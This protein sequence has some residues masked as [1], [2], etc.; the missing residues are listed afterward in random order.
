M[1]VFAATALSLFAL[2][3]FRVVEHFA[4]AVE[5]G[6]I[7]AISEALP[8]H[9][10]LARRAKPG[11]LVAQMV[12]PAVVHIVAEAEE[13]DR[14]RPASKGRSLEKLLMD[15]APPSGTLADKPPVAT[16]DG[17]AQSPIPNPQS[18]SSNLQSAIRNPQSM[19]REVGSGFIFNAD[20]GYVLTSAHVTAGGDLIHIFLADDR[21]AL[22]EVVAINQTLDLAVLRIPIRPL[23]KLELADSDLSAIGDDVFAVGSPFGL[24]GTFSKGIVSATDRR[25][26]AISEDEFE[27]L[28]Q[29][30]AVINPGNSGGPL[31]NMRGEVIGVN[32]AIATDGYV[33]D[34]I[35]FAIPANRVTAWLKTLH[36]GFGD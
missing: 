14:E 9:E 20:N 31:V 32:L 4:H 18:P 17:R 7:R 29:T 21:H 8:S 12:A 28:I 1:L 10:E 19:S 3:R 34:G 24:A 5:R 23:H 15:L 36:I 22:A 30:D 33:Y 16:S 26:I 6:R 13:P 35:G 2:L 11:R 25:H 27:G